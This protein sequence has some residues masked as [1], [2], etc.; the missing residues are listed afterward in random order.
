MFYYGTHN[1]GTAGPLVWWQWIFTWIFQLVSKCQDLSIKEQLD[2]GVKVFNLQVVWYKGE[3]HFSHGLCV[4]KE[5]LKDA[6]SLM[7]DY[8]TE[9]TR[10]YFQ[11]Y[12]DKNF[13]LGQ[14][15]DRF[16]DL[17]EELIVPCGP[18]Q[19]VVL[20]NAWIEGKIHIYNSGINI[21]LIE[22][23]W[24]LSWSK[25]NS[26]SWIDRLPLPKRHAKIYNSQ[27]KSEYK[28]KAKYLMLDFFE[29]G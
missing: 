6:I 18:T 25:F 20:L 13:F 11:L 4:Y 15:E 1:S 22:K 19:K 21:G 12:L 5:K 9:E 29:L 14:N 7:N 2:R 23:Y 10:I 3:W 24:T 17:I 16:Y 27:Y 28:D 8:A 26:K